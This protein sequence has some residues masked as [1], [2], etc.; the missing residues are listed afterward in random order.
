M[1]FTAIEDAIMTGNAPAATA[2]IA[3]GARLTPEKAK[4]YRETFKKQPK[5]LELI[6]MATKK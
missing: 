4:S 1:G 5:V 6:S 3:A 2:L